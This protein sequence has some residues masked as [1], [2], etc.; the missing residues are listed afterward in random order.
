MTGRRSGSGFKLVLG[1][2][3]R[4]QESRQ[5]KNEREGTHGY[6]PR[7]L[8]LE[9]TLGYMLVVYQKVVSHFKRFFLAG[10]II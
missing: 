5:D 2:R 6:L 8:S 1:G 7:G 4:R 10:M 9:A 3:T